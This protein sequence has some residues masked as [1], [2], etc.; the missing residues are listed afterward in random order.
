MTTK[1]NI[2]ITKTKIVTKIKLIM[3]IVVMIMVVVMKNSHFETYAH[4]YIIKKYISG[5]TLLK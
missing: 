2:K 1:I 4:V 3:I 5:D